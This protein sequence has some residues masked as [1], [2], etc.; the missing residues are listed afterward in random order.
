MADYEGS[1]RPT[2]RQRVKNELWATTPGW[3]RK[4]LALAFLAMFAGLVLPIVLGGHPEPAPSGAAPSAVSGFT[5]GGAPAAAEPAKSSGVWGTSTAF[6]L[7]LSFFA[8]FC[9]AWLLRL[10]FKIGLVIAGLLVAGFA[11]LKYFGV[12]PPDLSGLADQAKELGHEATR[13]AQ[14]LMAYVKTVVPSGIAAA[15]GLFVGWRRR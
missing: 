15:A 10:F 11:A 1:P 6:A 4:L 2:V 13:Q 5:S 9:V 14:G 7:G 8:G 12:E 3:S